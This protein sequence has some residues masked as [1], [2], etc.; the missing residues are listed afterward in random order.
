MNTTT[1]IY[2][3]RQLLKAVSFDNKSIEYIVGIIVDDIAANR[4]FRRVECLKILKR[5][6]KNRSS[7]KIYSKDLLRNLFYLY[8]HFIL[9]Y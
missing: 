8:Q 6:I 7:D 9:N 3:E 4:R 2:I 5:I 1:D